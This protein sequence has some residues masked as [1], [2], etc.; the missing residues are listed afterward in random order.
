MPPLKLEFGKG[1]FPALDESM[2]DGQIT[3][4]MVDAYQDELGNFWKRPGLS[5]TITAT[6]TLG[7]PSGLFW[8]TTLQK[9]IATDTTGKV[10]KVDPSTYAVTDISTG[11]AS[12]TLS[13]SLTAQFADNGTHVWMAAGKKM[14]YTDG[15]VVT[16]CSDPI[17][18]TTVTHPAFLDNHLLANQSGS[19]LFWWTDAGTETWGASNFATAD[20]EVD[21]IVAIASSFRELYLFGVRSTEVWYNTGNTPGTF[22]RLEGAFIER[23]CSAPYSIVKEDNTW[24]WLDHERQFIRLEGRSPKVISQPVNKVL[25]ELSSVADMVAGRFQYLNRR[26]IMLSSVASNLTLLYDVTLDAWYQWGVWNGHSYDLW[27]ARFVAFAPE[28]NLYLFLATDGMFYILNET[29]TDA[30]FLIRSSHNTFGTYKFKNAVEMLVRAKRG[31]VTDASS[32]VF[33]YRLNHNNTGF[34]NEHYIPLNSRGN[35]KPIE[36]VHRLGHFR[37]LQ[38]EFGQTDTAP[39][40][41]AIPELMMEVK[42]S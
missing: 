21:N 38:I 24:F 1:S 29:A 18:P 22:Q 16:Q 8:S 17:A 19:A 7:T 26:F 20:A 9:F 25:R 3:P 42:D 5:A 11:T 31:Y 34:K 33:W 14:S 4:A 13:G 2:S 35:Y 32:P 39:F 6:A 10:V 37:T 23:G 41:M 28:Y 36:H 30:R 15:T 12:S 40:S 27:N